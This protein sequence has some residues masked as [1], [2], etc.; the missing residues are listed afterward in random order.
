MV[1]MH[2]LTM[3][4]Q[5]LLQVEAYLQQVIP[6]CS[7]DLTEINRLSQALSTI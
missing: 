6:E 1:G 5:V 2:R 7:R 3:T 4:E